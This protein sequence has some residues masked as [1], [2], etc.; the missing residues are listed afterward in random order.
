GTH[1]DVTLEPKRK[2]RLPGTNICIKHDNEETVAGG[3]NE[4]TKTLRM[5][6][7]TRESL[8]TRKQKLRLKLILE[9]EQYDREMVSKCC[10]RETSTVKKE[11][12]E[13][14][15]LKC[16][17]N[18]MK[19]QFDNQQEQL[20]QNLLK[21]QE[22]LK[23]INLL[24]ASKSRDLDALFKTQSS[25][26]RQ[27]CAAANVKM[28]T[29][30]RHL[31]QHVML[32]DTL[33]LDNVM[34]SDSPE[35]KAKQNR[36]QIHEYVTGNRA[37]IEMKRKEREDELKRDEEN[38]RRHVE[39]MERERR[40]NERRREEEK[41]ALM[42]HRQMH[43]DYLNYKKKEREDTERREREIEL[44]GLTD[45]LAD[46]ERERERKKKEKESA[47]EEMRQMLYMKQ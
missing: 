9:Q 15:R 33:Y 6:N 40:E 25:E 20:K 14:E 41:L 29:D 28:F 27:D 1:Y 5:I 46:E 3:P 30:K 22:D 18:D 21:K 8:T 26:Y 10:E 37:L 45:W 4:T 11:D 44:A 34:F 23:R 16:K 24:N 31:K 35:E 7:N 32:W 38:Y 47:M 36:Q 43:V 17:L 13:I 39:E 2:I 12:L 42:R 19:R